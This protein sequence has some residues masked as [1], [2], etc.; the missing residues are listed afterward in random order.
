LPLSTMMPPTGGAVPAHVLG[1]RVHDDVRAPLDRLDQRR[2][3]DGVVDDHRHAVPCAIARDRLEVGD[4]AGRVAD[5]LEEHRL[6]LVVD[7]RLER[8]RRVVLG[9]AHLDALDGSMWA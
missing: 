2:G 5:G 1:Q 6:G 7:Q 8:L 4:V 9:E 3:R